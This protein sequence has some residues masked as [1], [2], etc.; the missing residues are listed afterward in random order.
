MAKK[1]TILSVLDMREVEDQGRIIGEIRKVI[2]RKSLM[3]SEEFLK[4]AR[5]S[6]YLK[7]GDTKIPYI[8]I[9]PNYLC[10]EKYARENTNCLGHV[11]LWVL[12]IEDLRN[13]YDNVLFY[14]WWMASVLPSRMATLLGEIDRCK[15]IYGKFDKEANTDELHTLRQCVELIG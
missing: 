5:T 3:F 15:E 9:T 13:V 12:S 7:V 8:G 1:N 6:D 10:L 2:G 4:K 11:S 14:V